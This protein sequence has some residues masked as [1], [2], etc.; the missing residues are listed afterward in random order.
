[1]RANEYAARLLKNSCPK[2]T[3]NTILMVF[4]MNWNI[5]CSVKSFT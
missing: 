1:M 2:T 5:G 4:S 3:K